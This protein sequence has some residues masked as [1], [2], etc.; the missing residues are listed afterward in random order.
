M[1][2]HVRILGG[3]SSCRLELRL[4]RGQRE[5]RRDRVAEP[6]PAVPALDE[7]LAL[8]VAGGRAVAQLFGTIRIHEHFA[9]DQPHVLRGSRLEDRVGGVRVHG[10]EYQRRRRAVLEQ[11]IDKDGS[12]FLCI[13]LVGESHLSRKCVSMQPVEQ[14]FA[15][16]CD[17]V[18]LRIVHVAVNEPRHDQFARA[19]LDVR[20]AGQRPHEFAGLAEFS[21][22]TVFDNQQPVLEPCYG[23]VV[24][25]LAGIGKTV[26]DGTAKSRTH[27]R[28]GSSRSTLSSSACS[29]QFGRSPALSITRNSCPASSAINGMCHVPRR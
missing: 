17:N 24:V 2:P 13:R 4:A 25:L 7:F 15:V 19:V 23:F 22:Q 29:S 28:Q 20:I 16:G 1:H 12:D 8:F 10:A 26:K 6:A 9:G 27:T 14:L 18:D 21:N 11:L 3:Q 5:T